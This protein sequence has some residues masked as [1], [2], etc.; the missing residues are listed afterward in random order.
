MSLF[1]NN[2]KKINGEKYN[3]I[4]SN[5]FYT[6][7]SPAAEKVFDNKLKNYGFHFLKTHHASIS[8][9]K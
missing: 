3:D 9:L 6:T 5:A 4:M 7:R 2:K 8:N 1:S